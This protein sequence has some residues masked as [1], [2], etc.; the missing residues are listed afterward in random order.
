M[1]STQHLDRHLTAGKDQPPY[2]YSEGS[3]C[4]GC[5]TGN[6]QVSDLQKKTL[7]CSTTGLVQHYVDVQN[8]SPVL[9]FEPLPM[10]P[11]IHHPLHSFA[12]LRF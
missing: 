7:T 9:C 2:T 11:C 8:L 12:A 1:G 5:V 4:L 10:L 6:V 3:R